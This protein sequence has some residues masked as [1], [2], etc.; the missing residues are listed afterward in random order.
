M[1]CRKGLHNRIIKI[2]FIKISNSIASKSK[3]FIL[4]INY[5]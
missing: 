3:T 4:N 5:A 1:S 2:K